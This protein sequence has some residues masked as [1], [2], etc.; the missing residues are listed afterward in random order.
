MVCRDERATGRS[1]SGAKR[2]TRCCFSHRGESSG[3]GLSKTRC[4]SGSFASRYFQGLHQRRLSRG[5]S[6]QEGPWLTEP[7]PTLRSYSTGVEDT[8]DEEEL[9][10]GL[11]CNGTVHVLF[12]CLSDRGVSGLSNTFVQDFKT[13]SPAAIAT[14]IAGQA[15]SQLA[16]GDRLITKP[17]LAAEGKRLHTTLAEQIRQDLLLTLGQGGSNLCRYLSEEHQIEIFLE[18]VPPTRRLVVFG[19]GSDAQPLVRMAKTVGWHVSVVDGR[20]RFARAERFP[21]A[22]CVLVSDIE[23]HFALGELVRGAAV[24]VMTHSLVQY[25]RWLEGALQNKPSYVGQLGLRERTERLLVRTERGSGF[26]AP[27]LSNWARLR[28]RHAG[29]RSHSC[30]GRD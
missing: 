4:T 6:G 7:G 29:M 24:A 17:G 11:G 2:W 22:D 8:S 12:E 23:H 20:A 3:I 10:F 1:I 14:V 15:G 26:R 27:V 25:L 21:E 9:N 5:G 30:V 18:Y 13:Q 19:V 28:W 16:I